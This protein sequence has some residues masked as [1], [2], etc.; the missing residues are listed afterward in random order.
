M[1]HGKKFIGK[2]KQA[3]I[4]IYFDVTFWGCTASL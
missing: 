4:I 2:T 1:I 3:T